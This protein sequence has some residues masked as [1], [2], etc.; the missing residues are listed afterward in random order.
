MATIATNVGLVRDEIAA[1]CAAAGRDP[2]T[3]RL[4]AVTKS[5][6]P[7]ALPYL[8]REGVFDY[9]ENRIE[10]LAAMAASAPA[11][12]SFH[13]IGRIQ[14]R[15]IP[16]IAAHAACVHGLDGADHARRLAASCVGRR[17]PV[18]LQVNVSAE[19]TKAGVAPEGLGPL[20]ATVRALPA[21]EAVGLMTMAPPPGEGVDDDAIL[22]CFARLR[23]L[24]REHGLQRLSMGMS[25]DF[26][27]AI[28][29]GATDVRIGS[30]LFA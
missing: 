22:A 26:A 5:V 1:S 4:I 16:A 2:A 8:A 11:G 12:A 23:D 17:L 28:R 9:G 27:L 29:A 10:H 20:L 24:A 25:G 7:E 15:Q 14:G 3:V 21:L 6:G 30:R 13:H 18:F 19:A